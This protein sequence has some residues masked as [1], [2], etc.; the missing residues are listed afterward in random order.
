MSKTVTVT[1]SLNVDTSTIEY[2]LPADFL[3]C[4]NLL[5]SAL[6]ESIRRELVARQPPSI[7]LNHSKPRILQPAKG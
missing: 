5:T 1:I 7:S 3:L 6:Q 2:S 4:Q